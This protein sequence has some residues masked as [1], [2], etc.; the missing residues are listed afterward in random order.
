M[1]SLHI[2]ENIIEELG[3]ETVVI[4]SVVEDDRL[5]GINSDILIGIEICLVNAG[6]VAVNDDCVAILVLDILCG[7]AG[8]DQL[9]EQLILLIV[10]DL[11][12]CI[13]GIAIGEC[14]LC[15]ECA[16]QNIC[17]IRRL[18]INL[19]VAVLIVEEVDSGV[20]VVVDQFVLSC[21]ACVPRNILDHLVDDAELVFFGNICSIELLADLSHIVNIDLIVISAFD[22]DAVNSLCSLQDILIEV[23]AVPCDPI[24]S[25]RKLFGFGAVLFSIICSDSCCQADFVHN[26]LAVAVNLKYAVSVLVLLALVINKLCRSRDGLLIE[27]GLALDDELARDLDSAEIRNDLL[28]AVIGRNRAAHDSCDGVH[29]DLSGD[30][31]CIVHC[32]LCSKGAVR[33]YSDIDV[34]E[35]GSKPAGLILGGAAAVEH[36]FGHTVD[37][38][39]AKLGSVCGEFLLAHCKDL[40]LCLVVPVRCRDLKRICLCYRNIQAELLVNDRHLGGGG[41]VS[42][43]DVDIDCHCSELAQC[44][45]GT[46]GRCKRALEK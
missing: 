37:E 9:S 7:H 26:M 45:D 1:N 34:A 20:V 46:G 15:I 5:E 39:R 40:R 41:C 14:I 23:E 35:A 29:V 3:V 24:D 6:L 16:V 32:N 27:I 31:C 43:T 2:A 30:L 8:S 10:V 25:I 17:H 44:D 13:E 21:H 11:D 18:Q 33:I 22:L 38:L 12:L 36:D 28:A 4:G 42:C 19:N